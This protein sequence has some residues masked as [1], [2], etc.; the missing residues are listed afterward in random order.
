[1]TNYIDKPDSEYTYQDWLTFVQ[2][3]T[4]ADVARDMLQRRRTFDDIYRA[5]LSMVEKHN[6]I[7]EVSNNLVAVVQ[8]WHDVKVEIENPMSLTLTNEGDKQVV[9][10]AVSHSQ[11]ALLRDLLV[12]LNTDTA[13]Q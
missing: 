12:S 3:N 10:L 7:K 6:Q 2:T 4:P 8:T 11:I 9:S 13:D 5:Y 1:M